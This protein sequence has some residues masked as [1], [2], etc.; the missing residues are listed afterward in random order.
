[1]NCDGNRQIYVP[2]GDMIS[3]G[4]DT[5]V[6]VFEDLSGIDVNVI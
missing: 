2:F 4:Q 6:T 1:M 3:L 5:K